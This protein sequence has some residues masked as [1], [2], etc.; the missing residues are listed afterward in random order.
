MLILVADIGGGGGGEKE[1]S[2]QRLFCSSCQS[3]T[4]NGFQ[5]AWKL[6]GRRLV[7]DVLSIIF[8]MCSEDSWTAPR[9]MLTPR[10]PQ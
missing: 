3:N 7:L 2:T 9:W 4:W 1:A 10:Q 8:E 5:K 6:P